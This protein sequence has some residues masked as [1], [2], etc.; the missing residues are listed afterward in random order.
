MCAQSQLHPF[1]LS[2]AP[3]PFPLAP[4]TYLVHA[5][6]P[7]AQHSNMSEQ[8][9]QQQQQHLLSDLLATAASSKD[10]AG[11]RAGDAFHPLLTLLTASSSEAWFKPWLAEQLSSTYPRASRSLLDAVLQ[12]RGCCCRV[13]LGCRGPTAHCLPL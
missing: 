5:A 13:G 2:P 8:P 7:L 4:P 3:P 6:D 1:W 11:T 10:N 9:H 12:V